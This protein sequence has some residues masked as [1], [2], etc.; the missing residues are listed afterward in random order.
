MIAR[1]DFD[2]VDRLKV[3]YTGH[4]TGAVV[5]IVMGPSGSGKST[6]A[7]ALARD[8]GLPFIEGDD[9]HPPAN[10]ARM[11]SG[12]ALTDEDRWPWLDAVAEA[13]SQAA[14]SGGAVVACS[15]LRRVYRDRL[16]G[17]IRAPV[18]FVL[19]D[20]DRAL[21]AERMSNRPG[22]YMPVSLLDSQIATLEPPEADE[23]VLRLPATES[24]TAQ[25]A[26]VRRWLGA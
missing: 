7:A 6:L 21:L 2:F 1:R 9:L 22:H 17:L 25:A 24:L 11:A 8:L 12:V 15:A 4:M 5:I 3:S 14:A 13:A 18:R 16:V 23:I 20:A 26:A 19:P 10:R